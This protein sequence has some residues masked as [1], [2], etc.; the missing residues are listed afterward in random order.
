MKHGLT[1]WMIIFLISSGVTW[2]GTIQGQVTLLRL[3]ASGQWGNTGD[4]GNAVVFVLGF[5]EP[6]ESRQIC[7][8]L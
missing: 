4:H 3:S 2:G 8:D 1:G 6:A 5:D 7:L